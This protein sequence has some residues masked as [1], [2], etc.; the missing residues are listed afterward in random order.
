MTA[1]AGRLRVYY[2]I[3]GAPHDRPGGAWWFSDFPWDGNNEQEARELAD[4]AADRAREF[5][6]AVLSSL[7]FYAAE[8]VL[9]P[10][11][12]PCYRMARHE[13][14]GRDT[15]EGAGLGRVLRLEVPA[16]ARPVFAVEDGRRRELGEHELARVP[17]VARA[18]GEGSTA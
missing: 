1:L 17:D 10:E 13:G 2:W 5:L 7:A 16:S 12:P 4:R 18:P 6:R 11:A 15:V 9:G 14:T 3:R 8:T